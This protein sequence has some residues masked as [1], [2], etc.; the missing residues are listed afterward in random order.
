MK[1]GA[2]DFIEKPFESEV[3]LDRVSKAI[4]LD[5]QARRDH[6]QCAEIE[7]RLARLTPRER[8]VMDMLIAGKANKMVAYELGISSRTV[9]IH[10]ARIMQK[11]QADSVPELVQVAL[12]FGAS[13][14]DTRLV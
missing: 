6:L 3:L 12:T 2:L 10:R 8:E 1:A 14:Q 13:H 5:A 7:Q 4:S 9:E 11:M